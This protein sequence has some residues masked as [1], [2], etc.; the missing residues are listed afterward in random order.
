MEKSEF[1]RE[2]IIANA[3]EEIQNYD[4]GVWRVLLMVLFG[5][6]KGLNALNDRSCRR[7]LSPTDECMSSGG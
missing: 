6:S 1:D 4:A 2:W 3:L 5:C 7:Q